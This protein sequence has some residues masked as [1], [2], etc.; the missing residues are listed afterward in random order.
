[1][2]THA[3]AH[4]DAADSRRSKLGNFLTNA[5]IALVSTVVSYLVL[6][7]IFFRLIF[8]MADPSI[9]PHLPETPGVLA[10]H[11]KADYVPHDY[12][13]I[14]GDSMAEGLGDALLAAA[15]NE[16]RAIHA[17]HVVRELTGKDVVSFGRGG[18]SSAEALVR[19]P[20]R[21]LAGSRCFI[22]PT[23]GDPSRIYAYFYEGNDIQDNLAFINKVAHKLG[24]SDTQAIDAYLSDDYGT[25]AAWRCHLYLFDIVSRMSRF[26]YKYYYLGVDPY[27]QEK[28]AT[29]G[30]SSMQV[31]EESIDA[32]A[33]LDGPALEL[34]DA[35]IRAGI[36]VFDRSLAWLKARF[37]A[38]P[39]TVVYVPTA[40]SIYQ[41]TGASYRYSI[42]PR[43]E[44]RSDWATVAQIARNSDLLCGLVRDATVRHGVGFLDTR[45]GLR[46]AAA[47]RVLHG[48]VDWVHFN[49]QG[50]RALGGILAGR[51][52][53][54]SVDTCK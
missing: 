30:G 43:E 25:F 41:L 22:F 45:P 51:T 50:Y 4:S 46:E 42:E 13:A 23:I 9:R 5:S 3:S 16:A 48:P 14:L 38:V 2:S 52:D 36:T 11:S 6:E 20:A 54:A 32:P 27:R 18:A 33:P 7:A 28:A 47:Q 49:E 24:R 1:M 34:A 53:P 35:D 21:I 12:V 19:R 17:A 37:P 44:N 26:F 10:Q 15:D 31:G 8:P 39:I 40:L 29:H